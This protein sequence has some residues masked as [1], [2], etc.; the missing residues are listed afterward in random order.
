MTIAIAIS[1][2]ARLLN[3]ITGHIFCYSAI[4]SSGVVLILPGFL[5]RE[6]SKFAISGLVLSILTQSP[7]IVQGSL[8]L[9]SKNYV[10]G[11]TKIVFA[12][13]Y[14]LILGFSLTLG[15]DLAFLMLP[16]FR[17]QRDAMS[18]DLAS[19]VGLIGV[20]SPTNATSPI[21]SL[22]GT[23]ILSQA[24]APDE[25]IIKYHYIMN[26]CYRDPGWPWILQPVPWEWLFFLVPLFVV[27]LACLNGQGIW[28]WR[29]WPMVI[30]GCC[31]FAGKHHTYFLESIY[32]TDMDIGLSSQ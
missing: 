12:I 17:A 15:S 27:C 26:G 3:S 16:S 14:S 11:S 2:I 10:T 9:A 30:I 24:I 18:A 20:Y 22:N 28:G 23:F 8:E 4:S 13:I 21:G 32:K 29:I 31:S 19:T 25:P 1:L 6:C 7:T 5:V